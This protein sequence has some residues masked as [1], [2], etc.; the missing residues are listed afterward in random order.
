MLDESE[1]EVVR[2]AHSRGIQ[3][4]KDYRQQN[5][6]SL[7]DTPIAQLHQPVQDAYERLT[8]ATGFHQD[9][10]LKHRLSLYGPPCSACGKPL[11]TPLAKMCAACGARRAV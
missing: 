7:R 10:I 4:V 6:A 9:H 1:F 3:A 5:G 2:K 11:R 8:G